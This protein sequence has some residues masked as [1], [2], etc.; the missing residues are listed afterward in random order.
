MT[1]HR[2]SYKEFTNNNGFALKSSLLPSPQRNQSDGW[3]ITD[4]QQDDENDGE[5]FK[6]H[7]IKQLLSAQKLFVFL[8]IQNYS[9]VIGSLETFLGSLGVQS[10]KATH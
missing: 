1:C 2:L 8:S 3:A 7:L 4:D 10:W 9:N 5:N 6:R